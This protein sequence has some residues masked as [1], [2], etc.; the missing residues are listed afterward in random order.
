MEVS[1]QDELPRMNFRSLSKDGV[2]RKR[3][4]ASR[5]RE[6]LGLDSPKGVGRAALG[7]R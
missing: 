1:N 5:Q 3:E 7:E 4:G 2:S 6:G